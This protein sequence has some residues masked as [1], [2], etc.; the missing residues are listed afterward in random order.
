MDFKKPI[1]INQKVT[2]KGR[3]LEVKSKRDAVI[4]GT[5]YNDN[6]ELCAMS[7]GTYVLFTPDVARRMNIMNAEALKTFIKIIGAA[8]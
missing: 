3:V 5:I 4:E 6:D 8:D 1:F 7:Q 2:A